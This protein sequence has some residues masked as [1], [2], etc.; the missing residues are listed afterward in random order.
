MSHRPKF[1]GL[2]LRSIDQD[3]VAG[4]I[5]RIVP[6]VLAVC[7]YLGFTIAFNIPDDTNPDTMVKFLAALI[8]AQGIILAMTMQ[9]AG[10]ILTNISQGEFSAYLKSI[11]LVGYYMVLVQLIQYIHLFSLLMLIGSLVAWLFDGRF[12]H[13]LFNSVFAI[14]LSSF[15][16]ALSWSWRMTSAIKDLIY[17]RSEYQYNE[18]LKKGTKTVKSHDHE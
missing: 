6:Y 9:T 2:L 12:S 10:T 11:G 5:R 17:Y 14:A 15:L 4:G 8:T 7:F 13:A 16:Y 1:I 3:Y 18:A